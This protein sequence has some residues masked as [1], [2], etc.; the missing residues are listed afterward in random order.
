M[1]IIIAFFMAWGNFIA[2]PCPYKKWDGRLKNYMLAML[3]SVG[4]VVGGLW[5]LLYFCLE[6]NFF[7]GQY[8]QISDSIKALGMMLYI[9]LISGFFHLDGFM[10]CSDA[11]LSRRP[12][13]DRQRILKDSRVGAFAVI[14][15]VLLMISWYA[16]L[17][18]I[19]SGGRFIYDCLF[20]L[21]IVSRSIAGQAVLRYKPMEHS[22]YK[23]TFHNKEKISCV[24]IIV[25][26]LIIYMVIT[27][28]A[29][30]LSGLNYIYECAVVFIFMN[31]AIL[32]SHTT[33]Y[34][35]RKQL[36][37]MSGDVAGYMICLSEIVGIVFLAIIQ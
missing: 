19:V 15:V 5:C 1:K 10:D 11:I 26:Q 4:A 22:Q 28:Y 32:A 14:S 7:L 23:E 34:Y 3:P 13:E 30:I 20:L 36:G 27:F 16:A 9:F 31:I 24:A 2:L 33:G 12:L 21:P 8:I 17:T 6:R 35:A 37:G 29:H 25:L 18:T